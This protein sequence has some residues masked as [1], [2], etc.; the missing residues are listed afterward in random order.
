MGLLGG[1]GLFNTCEGFPAFQVEREEKVEEGEALSH[2]TGISNLLLQAHGLQM[3]TTPSTLAIAWGDITILMLHSTPETN[4]CHKKNQPR[5]IFVKPDPYPPSEDI[6]GE[7]RA[8]GCN[9]QNSEEE[10]NGEDGIDPPPSKADRTPT[11]NNRQDIDLIV[12]RDMS[13][14]RSP[15]SGVRPVPRPLQL[16]RLSLLCLCV[17][18]FAQAPQGLPVVGYNADFKRE[19][20]LDG[21]LMIGGLFPV[22]QKGEGAEDCGKINAQ[23]GIQRLEAMLLALDEINK[24]DRILPGIRLGAHILDTCSKDTYA[25]EQSL[26]F[27]RASLTK[28]DDSEYTCPDGSYA[29]HDDVPLAISGVIGGSY[30]D[31]SIQSARGL[32]AASDGEHGSPHW[33]RRRVLQLSAHL[34]K[35][36]D[37][38][39]SKNQ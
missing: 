11:R 7:D 30:S 24:D 15:L 37:L 31:V 18:L 22:H 29:I 2:S 35:G 12:P 6:A 1:E 16:S 21:D 26:E 10:K 34:K 28:V 14:G 5:R 36:A 23:R 20:T 27:V 8:P 13:L 33:R 38:C 39:P 25:L 9:L 4:E 19:I 3:T 17:S 32:S